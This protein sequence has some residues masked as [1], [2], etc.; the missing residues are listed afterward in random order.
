MSRRTFE[1]LLA[2]GEIHETGELIKSETS[3]EF[4]P[5]YTFVEQKF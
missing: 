3:G 2:D 1:S 5:V 4:E